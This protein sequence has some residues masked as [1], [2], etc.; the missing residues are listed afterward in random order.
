MLQLCHALVKTF[1]DKFLQFL[2]VLYHLPPVLL[3]V[4]N[5]LWLKDFLFFCYPGGSVPLTHITIPVF[6]TST[7]H[8]PTLLFL[9]PLLIQ[10]WNML[11]WTYNFN[12]NNFTRSFILISFNWN[13]KK[14]SISTKIYLESYKSSKEIK[15]G[16][17]IIS[18]NQY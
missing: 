4:C 12:K 18:K 10:A 1:S 11:R 13:E 14:Y 9:L 6:I 8:L 17:N 15:V 16:N 5:H 3:I 7:A 2:C